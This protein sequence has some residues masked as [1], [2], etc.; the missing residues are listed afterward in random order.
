MKKFFKTLGWVLSWPFVLIAAFFN[1]LTVSKRARKFKKNPKDM[2]LEDRLKIVYKLFNKVLYLKRIEVV[3]EGFD[4]L[5]SKQVL[6]VA[7]HKSK[8]DPI[9]IYKAF[10]ESGHMSQT[11]FIAKAELRKSWAVRKVLELLNGI[12][13]QRDSGRSILECYNSEIER[14]KD[15]YSIVVFPEGTRIKGDVLGE[16]RPATLKVAMENYVAISPVA[17]YG[18]ENIKPKSKDGKHKVYVNALKLVQPNKYLNTKQEFLMQTIQED[19]FAV[20]KELIKKAQ[21]EIGK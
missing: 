8:Y 16:F 11:A 7:N 15:G 21:E 12:F 9:V 20:Y 18:T 3:A 19:I 6:M 5:P 17:I 10:Y 2:F 1:L 13:I 4:R 14:L